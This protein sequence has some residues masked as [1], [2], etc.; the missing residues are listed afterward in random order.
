MS[1]KACQ[2]YDESYHNLYEYPTI[3]LEDLK[4]SFDSYCKRI[5]KDNNISLMKLMRF[6][7]PISVFKPVSINVTDLGVCLEIDYVSKVFRQTNN[8]SMLSMRSESLNFI[9][10]NSFGFD[11]LTVNGF[12]EDQAGGFVGATK[13][14]QLKI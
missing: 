2:K 1:L 6:L 14:Q 9:F 13:S 10:R 8:P 4:K 7:S 11:T 5:H 12:E 3:G